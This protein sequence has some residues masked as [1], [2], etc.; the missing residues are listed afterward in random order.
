MY[1]R[2]EL[3][4]GAN[5]PS[6][7]LPQ[8]SL[9]NRVGGGGEGILSRVIQSWRREGIKSGTERNG[10]RSNCCTIQTRTPDILQKIGVNMPGLSM[11][12]E[13]ISRPVP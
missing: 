2:D 1:A 3:N 6:P 11:D 12:G 5:A 13:L 9:Q 7:L 10:T 4:I 8:S